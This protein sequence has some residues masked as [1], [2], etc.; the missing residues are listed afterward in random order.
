[1]K[2]WFLR[3]YA[4]RRGNK[5]SNLIQSSEILLI[6]N[7]LYLPKMTA[8]SF[9]MCLVASTLNAKN[10]MMIRIISRS[11]KL[12][13]LWHLWNFEVPIV[14]VPFR[15][16]YRS[17]LRKIHILH[18]ISPATETLHIRCKRLFN[19]LFHKLRA[20]FDNFHQIDIRGWNHSLNSPLFES[21]RTR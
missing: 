11:Q 3:E 21:S 1:M 17:V 5:S 12:W 15:Q 13:H 16:H 4:S 6:A 7:F 18:Q 10:S 19:H 14:M 2:Q 20:A 8:R 9:G